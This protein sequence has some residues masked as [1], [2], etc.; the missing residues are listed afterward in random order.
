MLAQ[1]RMKLD[2]DNKELGY[3]QSSNLQGV[4]MERLESNYAERMHMSGLKPY[5]QYLTG[6]SQKEWIVNTLST[7]A[8]QEIICPLFDESFAGFVLEKKNLRVNIQSK[9][10]KR[11][12]KQELLDEFYS[13]TYDRY[14][15]LEFLTPT[16]FRS[17]GTYIIMPDTRYVYQSLMNKYSAASAH[18]DLYDEETLKQLVNNSKIVRYRLKST[19]FPL[20]GVKIPSFTG[21]ICIKTTGASTLAKYVR[22]LAR[23][24]EYS[25]VGIKTAIGMGGLRMNGGR[26]D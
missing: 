8:Y 17:S 23:F 9:E 25:G 21:E 24:G 22:L 11:V 13:N 10:L 15:N 7:E 16:S 4:L 18:M 20:E 1:L 14:V 26:N 12:D 19:F 3:Y 5:S 2:V 6:G